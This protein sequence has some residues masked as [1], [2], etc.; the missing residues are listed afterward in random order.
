MS[1]YAYVTT[2]EFPMTA[3]SPNKNVKFVKG[4][5][6]VQFQASAWGPILGGKKVDRMC[7][8]IVKLSWATLP[9]IF[10]IHKGID[11]SFFDN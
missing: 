3:P 9:A 7:K 5:T 10:F 6:R 11:A 1:M 8:N 2:K 4:Q